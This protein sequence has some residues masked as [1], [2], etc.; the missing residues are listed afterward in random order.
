MDSG[1]TKRGHRSKILLYASM[2]Q[3]DDINDNKNI[4]NNN[5]DYNYIDGDVEAAKI[6]LI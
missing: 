2:I 1:I 5:N 6:K 3:I 4:I